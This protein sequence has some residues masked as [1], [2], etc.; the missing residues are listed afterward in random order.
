MTY[1]IAGALLT[2]IETSRNSSCSQTFRRQA[3]HC[4][5]RWIR[6]PPGLT[7]H[8][9]RKTWRNFLR[10][11]FV[12]S[13]RTAWISSSRSLRSSTPSSISPLYPD[14]EHIHASSQQPWMQPRSSAIDTEPCEVVAIY[15]F[16]WKGSL[17]CYSRHISHTQRK[18]R[19]NIG[20]SP[21]K[22]RSNSSQRH[23]LGKE[24]PNRGWIL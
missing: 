21:S 2:V 12:N 1:V 8:T 22:L 10:M 19:K 9:Q 13:W 20:A 16:R 23:S 6:Q 7:I 17:S 3:P 5:A 24:E 14:P 11:N 4:T 18:T 15:N